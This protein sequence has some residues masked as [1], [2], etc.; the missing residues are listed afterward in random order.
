MFF[1]Y[2]QCLAN[3][4]FKEGFV[5]RHPFRRQHPYV[6]FGFGIVKADAEQ[7][8]AMIFDLDEITVA[9]GLC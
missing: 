8:L 9:G 4:L 1:A 3:T 5:H 6:N 2:G 7:T